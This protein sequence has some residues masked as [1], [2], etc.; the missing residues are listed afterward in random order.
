MKC[1]NNHTFAVCAYK[2]SEHLETCIKSLVNQT[3]KSK[4]IISTS[5]PN[6][7]IYNIAK[8][9][10]IPVYNTNSKSDIQDDW[11]FAYNK[12]DTDYVTVAHQDDIYRK[13]YLECVMEACN[14]YDDVSIAFTD[15]LPIKGDK[16]NGRDKNSKFR[17]LLR[18][19]LKISPLANK[20]FVK[21]GCLAFG[22]SICCPSVTYHKKMLGDTIFT[23][24]LRFGLDWDTFEKIASMKGRFVY[25]DKPVMCYRVYEGATTNEFIVNHKREK[26]DIYMFNK[27][28]PEFI[29]KFIMKF[30]VKAYDT[31]KE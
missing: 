15:Y 27:F 3:S 14:N 2:E 13:E 7:Y 31:Y 26:E 29:T 4:I 24:E 8:K 25:V 28:W 10:D 20:R 11:N 12:A 16:V 23:S 21:R 9:Y 1:Y 22:N 30:Y 5:T 6:D 19:P 18:L 17:R